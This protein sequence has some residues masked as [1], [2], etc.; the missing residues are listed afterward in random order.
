MT[1][2]AHSFSE[3]TE[4]MLTSSWMHEVW[5]LVTDCK[6]FRVGSQHGLKESTFSGSN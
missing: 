4:E 1:S 3:C 6:T 5:S 2:K